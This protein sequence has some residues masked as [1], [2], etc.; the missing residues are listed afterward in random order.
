MRVTRSRKFTVN[1]GNYE[2]Y[3]FGG[4]IS[5]SNYDLG[6]TDEQ[7]AQLGT[8]EWENLS[9]TMEELAL[10]SLH[11]LLVDEV[12][13][14]ASLTPDRKTFLLRALRPQRKADANAREAN[15]S[16]RRS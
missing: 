14:T 6:F 1:M 5:V 16:T 9:K 7:V 13:E 15:S 2:S 8:E 12:H 11:N 4:E 10:D 3:Q